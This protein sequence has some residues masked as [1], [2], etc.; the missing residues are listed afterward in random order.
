VA[1]PTATVVRACDFTQY[2]VD[3]QPVYDRLIL[4]DITPTDSWIGNMKTGSW[5]NFSGAEHTLDRFTDVYPDT[6]KA[7]DRV[8]VANCLGNPCDANRFEIGFGAKRISYYLERQAWK[9]QLLCYDQEMHI[10]HARDHLSQIISNVLRP[11]SSAIMSM[12]MR[13]RAMLNAGKKWAANRTLSDFTFNF[14]TGPSAGD[15]E[16]F[17]DMSIAP[18]NVFKL[19]PQMLQRRFEPLMRI[20]YAGKNPFK[21]TAP[22]IELV[23]DMD[24]VW[25]LD[26]LGG[27]QGIG[28][29]PSVNG[30]W[31]FEQWGAANKYWRYGFTGSIGNFMVRSD[32]SNIRMNFVRD[33]GAGA[34]P[35][36]YR[37]QVILPYKNNIT[38]G[39]GGAP[40]LGR[41]DNPDFS[42]AQF[43]IGY[44]WH[45]DGMEALVSD[46]TP[47]NPMMPYGARDFGGGWKFV[48]D[49]LGGDSNNRP[50]ENFLRNKGM[51]VADFKLGIRPLHTEFVEAIF[52][53]SEPQCVIEISPCATDPGYPT[54]TYRTANESCGASPISMAFTPVLA[55][56]S[57]GSTSTYEVLANSI[58][59]NQE[60]I[61]HAAIT[62]TTTIA[63]LAAQLNALAPSL[64]LW[65][66]NATQVILSST[67]CDNVELPFQQNVP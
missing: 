20:G 41:V 33:L 45:K 4:E 40:G 6:T 35:N 24:T 26:H 5:A 65:G 9:T 16:I 34:A 62:G 63:A 54:Q 19:T 49:N 58:E 7:W 12:F 11:A 21:E 22:F 39:A 56:H 8:Q 31:R 46:A 66:N 32:P 2:L 29:V 3:Q 53:K 55:I 23:A 1:C 64:G 47:V 51:F 44:I 43:R 17:I 13:K 10:T 60:P 27:Q 25:E 28:G 52:Y 38:G 50:I 59:C 30:S 36:R 42:T 18:T 61:N 67:D 14:T 57:D 15:G 37:Y 48:M